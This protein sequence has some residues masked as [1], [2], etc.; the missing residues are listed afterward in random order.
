MTQPKDLSVPSSSTKQPTSVWEKASLDQQKSTQHNSRECVFR[1]LAAEGGARPAVGFWQHHPVADQKAQSLADA[2]LTFYDEVGGDLLKITPAGT[3]QATSLGLRDAWHGDSLGRRTI[4]SRP[5]N[6]PDDWLLLDEYAEG[7]IEKAV[8]EATALVRERL[9]PGVALF[10]TVISPVTQALQLAGPELLASHASSAP[11]ALQHGLE[12]LVRRT[13]ALL[14]RYRAAG[15]DGIYLALQHCVPTLQTPENYAAHGR[16][17][18]EAVMAACI[19]FRGR[20]LHLHGNPLHLTLPRPP[21]DWAVHFELGAANPEP[22]AFSERCARPLIAGLTTAELASERTA[23][24][25][26]NR[27]RAIFD[28]FG[29]PSGLV[30]AGCVL[31]LDFPLKRARAWV[32][33]I[34]EWPE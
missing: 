14:E 13:Y 3:Y 29:Q 27:A 22:A 32:E 7:P 30:T 2:A 17:A 8:I 21:T 9:S 19:R 23:E 1:A 18:D 11:Q 4:V 26:R 5:I 34:Q 31:P 24:A 10:A 25:I 6:T 28:N 15:A 33:A 20:I 16:W 12:I